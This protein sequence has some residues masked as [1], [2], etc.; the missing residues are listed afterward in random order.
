YQKIT[1]TPVRES[2]QIISYELNTNDDWHQQIFD[3]SPKFVEQHPRLFK[4]VS[5]EW[6]AYNLPYHFYP[7]P[8]SVLVLGAGTGNDVAAAVR[9]G[10]G[11]V[12]A[13]EID[14]LILRLGRELHF[15]HPYD[16]PRVETVLDDARSYI[17]NSQQQFDMIVFSL[18]DSHTNVGYYS[19]IR[20]DNY[21]YTLEAL[22]SAKRLL[23]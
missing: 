8:P 16:S 21:V 22:Q 12:V 15:E 7:S 2:N 5:V 23:K 10:A 1:I 4:D 3:L 17:Q 14:P 9:N 19:N 6:N 11:H 13:V 18:L 20:T